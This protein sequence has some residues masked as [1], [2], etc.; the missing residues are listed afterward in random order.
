MNPLRLLTAVPRFALGLVR[1]ELEHR[2]LNRRRDELEQVRRGGMG[3]ADMD[4]VLDEM[5]RPRR[6][7][8]R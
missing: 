3:N 6:E 1:D 8:T 4:R 2:K 7:R 5:R